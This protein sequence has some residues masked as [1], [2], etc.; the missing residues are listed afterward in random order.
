VSEW[1]RSPAIPQARRLGS[2]WPID[3]FNVLNDRSAQPWERPTKYHYGGAPLLAGLISNRTLK[4]PRQARNLQPRLGGAFSW[5]ADWAGTTPAC[6]VRHVAYRRGADL[7]SKA[8]EYRAKAG[9]CDE[10]AAQTR[11]PVIKQQLIE[12]AQ[13]WRNMLLTKKSTRG[14]PERFFSFWV[15]SHGGRHARRY[16][17]FLAPPSG[18]FS[19]PFT[20]RKFLPAIGT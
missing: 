7:T 11:D 4:Q 1:P 14:R 16:L 9:E 20:V 6:C 5:A 17:P 8:A 13:Q 3:G 18:A 15:G 2:G 12:I 10:R 19:L